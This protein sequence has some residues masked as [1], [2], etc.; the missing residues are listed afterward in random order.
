MSIKIEFR[1]AVLTSLLMLLWLIVEYV[2]GLQDTF[3]AFYPYVS[4]LSFLIP[5]FTYRLALIEK[6]EQKFGKLSFMQAFLSCFL[7]TVFVSLL[8]IPVQ[9]AFLKL[10]N[11]DFLSSMI[12]YASKSGKQTMESAAYYL[13]VSTFTSESVLADFVT[14]TIISLIMAWSMRTVK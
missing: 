12:L 14:G 11:P 9:L 3:I 10:I 7:M 2:V 1:Y 13:N 8:S 4:L 5:F 6:I